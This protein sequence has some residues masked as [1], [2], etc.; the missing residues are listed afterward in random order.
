[1][2]QQPPPS[3]RATG[4][5][6][7]EL[8]APGVTLA[9]KFVLEA[10]KGAGG[11]AVVYKGHMLPHKQPIAVKVML[12]TP[13]PTRHAD[14]QERFL[15]EARAASR[16]AHPGIVQ[17]FHA[18][19]TDGLCYLIMEWL[20]GRDLRE[21]LDHAETLP[22]ADALALTL[23]ALDALG[24]AHQ[25]GIVHKDLKPSNLFLTHDPDGA[26]RL[27]VLDFGVA[28]S[29]ES[30]RSR[31][32]RTGQPA[33]TPAYA[34]PEYLTKLHVSPAIDVYQMALILVEMLIGRPLVERETPLQCVFAHIR[35]QL[36][37]PDALL[38]GILGPILTK[39]LA[40]DPAQ[41]YPHAHAFAQALAAVEPAEVFP[42][43]LPPRPEALPAEFD[44]GR[45]RTQEVP[46]V[47][48]LQA[49]D[50]LRAVSRI[51]P[52]AHPELVRLMADA[53]GHE[54][55]WENDP[56]PLREL[57][58]VFIPLYRSLLIHGPQDVWMH[59]NQL[60][61]HLQHLLGRP[62]VLT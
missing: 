26:R 1:L 17:T 58:R 13:D 32:T 51:E 19:L 7:P 54:R 27:K 48:A 47:R 8:L 61:S 60:K 53:I 45:T 10:E 16:I 15:R 35:G 43:D 39:A 3:K 29:G 12:P 25:Q 2:Q 38:Q 33:C 42:L 6:L 5:S 4:S 46:G 24:A 21:E 34:A 36:N 41:R 55:A 62:I 22:V 52:H 56:A 59:I 23:Q 14:Y 49:L 50:R 11:C 40:L 28:H 30:D 20:E 57:E 9:G 37:L 44:Q 18:G 31:L